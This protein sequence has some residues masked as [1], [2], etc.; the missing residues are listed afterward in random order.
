MAQSTC[1]VVRVVNNSLRRHLVGSYI[2]PALQIGYT[3]GFLIMNTALIPFRI[4]CPI[5]LIYKANPLLEHIPSVWLLRGPQS[6]RPSKSN[7][8]SCV[9]CQR[10]RSYWRAK[11]DCTKRPNRCAYRKAANTPSSNPVTLRWRKY[12]QSNLCL[13]KNAVCFRRKTR[14]QITFFD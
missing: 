9:D 2:K 3:N 11:H 1:T 6:P 14:P 7:R 8:P 13:Y 4:V 12:A 10:V 5:I